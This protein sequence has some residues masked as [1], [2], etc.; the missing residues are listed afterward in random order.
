MQEKQVIP[1]RKE[2]ATQTAQTVGYLRKNKAWDEAFALA[3]ELLEDKPDNEWNH[4]AMGWLGLDMLKFGAIDPCDLAGWLQRFTELD[5]PH[6]DTVYYE[7]LQW[8]L[9]KYLF[10]LN[11]TKAAALESLLVALLW[12]LPSRSGPSRS[13]LLKSLLK[14]KGA[15]LCPEVLVD[16]WGWDSFS[17]DDDH[18]EILP[19]G[20]KLPS[21]VE[22]PHIMVARRLLQT[23]GS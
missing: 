13:F 14:H 11:E 1:Q 21:L 18:E 17:P 3:G 6:Q 23:E 7:Q 22:R 5:I 10:G 8:R 20:R 9:G 16:V 15:W 2:R 4:R 12:R 19:N